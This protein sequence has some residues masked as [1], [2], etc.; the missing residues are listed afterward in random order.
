[1]SDTVSARNEKAGISLLMPVVAGL[2][3]VAV[4]QVGGLVVATILRAVDLTDTSLWLLASWLTGGGL[5]GG[6]RQDVTSTLGPSFGWTVTTVGAPLLLTLLFWIALGMAARRSSTSAVP[7]A[8]L[9]GLGAAIGAL[10]L[11]LTS[12]T[13]ETVTNS[14]GS[15]TTTEYLPLW[16]TAGTRPGVVIGAFVL[17]AVCWFVNTHLRDMWLAVRPYVVGLLI[18]PGVVVAVIAGAGLGYLISNWWAILVVPLLMPLLGVSVLFGA[19]GAPTIVSLTRIT[20]EPIGIWS[21]GDSVVA[22]LVGLAIL[23]LT[24]VIVGLVLRRRR[25]HG[26]QLVIVAGVALTSAAVTWAQSVQID[27]PNAL[28]AP[29]QLTVAWWAAA[30][31]GALMALIATTVAGNRGTKQTAASQAEDHHISAGSGGSATS[32]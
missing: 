14:A 5:L 26:E 12:H 19:A 9:A 30:I 17:G 1:M 32:P 28:G 10:T 27:P 15:V 8:L 25:R 2:I 31:I 18:I 21:W 6:W 24:A 29:T 16:W 20:P 13:S 11:S 23:V 22:G 7:A 4:T 3:A